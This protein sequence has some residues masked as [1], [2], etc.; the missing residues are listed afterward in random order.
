MGK[1]KGF[2]NWEFG[3]EVAEECLVEQYGNFQN[4]VG[5]D[6]IIGNLRGTLEVWPTLGGKCEIWHVS[7]SCVCGTLSSAQT[8]HDTLIQ[9][10]K[11]ETMTVLLL[12]KKKKI[13]FDSQHELHELF[14]KERKKKKKESQYLW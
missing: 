10:S 5:V 4:L 14:K 7:L 13:P 9:R 12:K 6:L 1:K 8:D 11:P 2:C 3:M